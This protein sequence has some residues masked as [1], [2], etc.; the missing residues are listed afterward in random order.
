MAS[1]GIWEELFHAT[2][3]A[4]GER[5]L[6]YVGPARFDHGGTGFL[7]LTDR[8][9]LY[10]SRPTLG[11]RRYTPEYEVALPGLDRISVHPGRLRTTVSI[12][13]QEFRFSR[14]FRPVDPG[15][16]LSFRT[17]VVRARGALLEALA[18]AAS[19]AAAP[20]ERGD[21]P[22]APV[23]QR[24]VIREVVRIPCRYCRQLVDITELRCPSCGASVAP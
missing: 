11:H 22:A 8:R 14:L 20:R 6:G 21:G 1:D 18:R 17:E 13:D 23:V 12:N 7:V 24:E 9:L 10:V 19:S 4:A 5:H 15:V 3:P 2:L 16:V